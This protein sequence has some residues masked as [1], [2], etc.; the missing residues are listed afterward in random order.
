MEFY[1]LLGRICRRFHIG[2]GGVS[3]Y[4]LGNNNHIEIH[5]T[6]RGIGKLKIIIYGNN[7]TVVVGH[8]CLLCHS[9]IIFVQGDDNI[10]KIGDDVSF[11]KNVSLVCCEGTEI[12]IG[13]DCM[14][15]QGVRI[16]TSDQHPIYDEKGVRINPAKSV[17]IGKHVWIGATSLIMKGVRIDDGS[18]I[19]INSM[20][21]KDIPAR[22]IAVGAPAKVIKTNVRWKRE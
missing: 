17:S 8:S 7:N 20:V 13:D 9:N 19:G 4:E 5:S 18:I 21:T 12:T 3:L 6:F 11:D 2:W 14:F 1:T 16:R 22:T 15:A 10:V